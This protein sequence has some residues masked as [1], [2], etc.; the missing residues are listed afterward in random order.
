V[1]G[2]SKNKI[3]WIRS[4]QLKKFRD[5]LGVFI[6]EGEKMVNEAIA[7]CPEQIESICFLDGSIKVP[8]GIESLTVTEKELEQI[9]CLKTP[10]KALAIVRKPSQNLHPTGTGLILALDGIQDP[11]NLGTILRIADWFGIDQVVCSENTVECFNPKV[12]Q[13]TMGAIF[14]V[15][16]DYCDLSNWL[17]SAKNPIYGALLEGKNVYETTLEKD[18]VLLMGNEGKGISDELIDLISHPIMIPRFGL[19]ESLNV[20]VATG[21][22][23]SEFKRI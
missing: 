5:E 13:A 3:K 16:I 7:I 2:L 22:L 1:S 18:A 19:A 12:V 11:G 15:K 9:S 17:K 10:N 8:E 20:S 6:V 21:I 14:R 4:L 23:V